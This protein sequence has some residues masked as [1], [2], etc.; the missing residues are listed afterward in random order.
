MI[1]TNESPFHKRN[2]FFN[3]IYRISMKFINPDYER[4]YIRYKYEKK[5][6]L[7]A[8]G[9]HVIFCTLM[10]TIRS[11]QFAINNYF[12]LTPSKASST[13]TIPVAIELSSGLIIEIIIFAISKVQIMRGFFL[14]SCSVIAIVAYSLYYVI[15]IYSINIP[16]FIPIS[17]LFIPIGFVISLLYAANWICGAIQTIIL[18]SVL[19]FNICIVDWPWALDKAML[20][21]IGISVASCL[22]IVIYYIEIIQR[23]LF[24]LRLICE[25]EKDNLKLIIDKLP[26][27]MILSKENKVIYVNHTFSSLS[28][29]EQSLSEIGPPPD[30]PQIIKETKEMKTENLSS[31]N[32]VEDSNHTLFKSEEEQKLTQL[33]STQNKINL[34]DLISVG[35]EIKDEEFVVYSNKG[36]SQYFSASSLTFKISN[37]S[38]QLFLLKNLTYMHK[39]ESLKEREKCQRIYFASITHDFRSPINVIIGYSEILIELLEDPLLKE[40]AVNIFNASNFISFLVQDV[41]DYSLHKSG[42]L[43]LALS[44]FS[45]QNQLNLIIDIYLDKF[46]DKGLFLKLDY[47]MNIPQL[48]FNDANRIMQVL[49]N[50]IGN[51]LKF[52]RQGGVTIEASH[53]E[54]E[55]N[56]IMIKVIDTGVGMK[57]EDKKKLFQEFGKLD[58]HKELNPMGIGLGL[59]ICKQIV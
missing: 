51:A 55:S 4:K 25:E 57:K 56:L 17:V 35:L 39:I 8:I 38:C 49:T 46:S 43:E 32:L 29:N 21:G 26:E 2:D 53:I 58:T 34:W 3:Q 19:E 37:S 11:I 6:L 31:K 23:E 16:M 50:L 47:G 30:N 40:Y 28:L 33:F 54:E 45:L 13:L 15:G 44:E 52:T 48:I 22:I 24:Y 10:L 41:L 59:F 5:N 7:V 42:K 27:A 18:I 14:T 20:I 12:E 1:P 9:M 36:I